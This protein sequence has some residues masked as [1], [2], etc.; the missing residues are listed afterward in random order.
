MAGRRSY[1]AGC[2]LIRH[3]HFQFQSPLRHRQLTIRLQPFPPYQQY[4]RFLQCLRWGLLIDSQRPETTF[5]DSSGPVAVIVAVSD[6]LCRIT[7]P[8]ARAEV[9]S[10]RN[11]WDLREQLGRSSQASSLT[12]LQMA[13]A[14]PFAL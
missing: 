14:K 1:Q 12:L 10:P 8:P 4:R 7:Y 3:R 9:A 6:A 11:A 2:Q 13:R 5:H